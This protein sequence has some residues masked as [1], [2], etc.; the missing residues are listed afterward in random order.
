[1]AREGA[2]LISSFRLFLSLQPRKDMAICP[3][4]VLRKGNERSFSV[5][6]R[7]LMFRV[8][9]LTNRL[10]RYSG[11]RPFSDLYI[12]M[13]VSLLI[14]S[15]TVSHFKLRIS[16]I[17]GATFFLFV[18]ILAARFCNFRKVC[19]CVAPHFPH[20]EQQNR[21]WGSTM[22]RYTLIKVFWGRSFLV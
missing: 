19:N 2:W 12:I 11:T 5:F 8:E 22:P 6:L 3:L 17:A 7:F 20:T 14:I 10:E 9:F 4:Y 21:K 18:T 13:A 1:M 16:G 15:L